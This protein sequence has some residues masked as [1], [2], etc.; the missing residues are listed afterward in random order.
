MIGSTGTNLRWYDVGLAFWS[1]DFSFFF[2][3]AVG[4]FLEVNVGVVADDVDCGVPIIWGNMVFVAASLAIDV[5]LLHFVIMHNKNS[6]WR[7]T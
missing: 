6:L 1:D 3:L 2:D 7:W 4:V 5:K